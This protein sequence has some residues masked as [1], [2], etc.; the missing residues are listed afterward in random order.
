MPAAAASSPVL[1][2]TDLL[3]QLRVDDT[4]GAG[5][6]AVAGGES[7]DA[8]LTVTVGEVGAG[9]VRL[10]GTCWSLHRLVI[11]LDHQLTRISRRSRLP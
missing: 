6:A 4:T 11:D 2:P 5:V 9:Q 8:L 7:G 3:V 1:T 10:V